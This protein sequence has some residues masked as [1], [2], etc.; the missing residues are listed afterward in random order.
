MTQF[1]TSLSAEIL[2][3]AIERVTGTR[4]NIDEKVDLIKIETIANDLLE[5]PDKPDSILIFAALEELVFQD[6]STESGDNW[7]HAGK[8][9]SK[10]RFKGT[11]SPDDPML[12]HVSFKRKTTK[13]NQTEWQ[14]AHF[15]NRAHAHDVDNT[16]MEEFRA[17]ILQKYFGSL[18]LTA[19]RERNLLYSPDSVDRRFQG[20]ILDFA[21][22][23][24]A[25]RIALGEA[26]RA[27]MPRLRPKRFSTIFTS[28]LSIARQQHF[29]IER[30]F[31][32]V[33]EN[34][35][36]LTISTGKRKTS[37]RYVVSGNNVFIK[38]R[39]LDEA[40][41]LDVAVEKKSLQEIPEIAN[42]IVDT[43]SDN[44]DVGAEMIHSLREH[45]ATG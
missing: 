1:D 12:D 44:P 42:W 29:A 34:S 31:A 41:E 13:P 30:T 14:A 36:Q 38:I 40:H 15:L 35:S 22:N 17:H 43:L 3:Q 2:S 7:L 21:M 18:V 9:I 11:V 19:E 32:Y 25:W 45:L 27:I 10:Q 4:L 26:E 6:S 16:S 37:L 28:L 20:E 24:D 8:P 39:K 5:H 33:A 23:L